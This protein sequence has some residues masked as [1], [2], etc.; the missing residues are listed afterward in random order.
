MAVENLGL[1]KIT[2]AI[3]Y[4]LPVLSNSTHVHPTINY[5]AGHYIV[6]YIKYIYIYIYVHVRKPGGTGLAFYAT[7]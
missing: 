7:L 3:Y 4:I 5:T 6:L 1:K 2:L